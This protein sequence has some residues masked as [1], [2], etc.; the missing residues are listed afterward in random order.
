MEKNSNLVEYFIQHTDK[1]FDDIHTDLKDIK[2]D[3]NDLKNFRTK[4]AVLCAAVGSIVT[5]L[6][7]LLM[8][9]FR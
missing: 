6:L 2:V 5:I 8:V 7:E 3:I 9:Y 4:I 1:R